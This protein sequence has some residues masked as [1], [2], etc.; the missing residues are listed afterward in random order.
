MVEETS[1]PGTSVTIAKRW[2]E[3]CLGQHE[4]CKSLLI[5]NQHTQLPARLIEIGVSTPDK[6]RLWIRPKETHLAINPRYMTL[7]HC[8]GSARI[9]TLRAETVNILM[10]GISVS[11]L[12]RTFREAIY[13]TK[14]MGAN[15]LWIDS[16]CILQDSVGDWQQEASLMADVYRGSLCNI[17]ATAASNAYAG[18]L[19]K[20]RSLLKP[21]I[22]KTMWNDGFNDE[23]I[24]YDTDLWRS[25]FESDPLRQ[26]A[27][28]IQELL[29]SPRII[30]L[31]RNQFFL[32]VLR[33]KEMWDLFPWNSRVYQWWSKNTSRGDDTS[34]L[35]AFAF[36]M[37]HFDQ[38]IYILQLDQ[39]WG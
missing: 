19:Y 22:V 8:W 5:R 21:C 10:S 2:L 33:I 13:L 20:R 12:P 30:H 16:L 25:A 32:G 9:L 3:D 11:H 29:L 17:A 27:W 24:I 1:S 23:Y 18:C 4:K 6:V 38:R 37:G 39:T 7:S 28:V 35:G 36:E 14:Q 34:D 26:R 15:F 31:R